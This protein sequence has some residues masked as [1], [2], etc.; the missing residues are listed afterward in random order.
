MKKRIQ[1]VMILAA[2]ICMSLSG[3]VY[4]TV[5]PTSTSVTE[6][7][8]KTSVTSVTT[9]TTEVSV[10]EVTEKFTIPSTVVE[11]TTDAVE[12]VAVTTFT[13]P[14]TETP[15]VET[16]KTHTQIPTEYYEPVE[17]TIPIITDDTKLTHAEFCN[18]KNMN[19]VASGLVDYYIAKGM[20][21]DNSI[22]TSNSG[23]MYVYQGQVDGQAVRS[24]NEHWDRIVIGM[25]EQLE[26]FMTMYPEAKYTDLSFNCYEE[27]QPNGEYDIY[28][29][30]K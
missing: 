16:E 8:V 27:L 9:V 5:T 19:R 28:F 4:T 3:C 21:Y 22:S 15:K 1:T 10:T 14:Q 20:K 23:W 6:P 30:Y 24:Y 7:M 2:M 25:D 18:A 12:V 29:C 26:A 17:T 13:A 11:T